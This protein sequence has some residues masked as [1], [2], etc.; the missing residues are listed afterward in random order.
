MV[1]TVAEVQIRV[2]PKLAPT[3]EVLE[4]RIFSNDAL[5]DVWNE[6]GSDDEVAVGTSKNNVARETELT[7]WR[8]RLRIELGG[9]QSDDR[10]TVRVIWSG[11]DDLPLG[12]SVVELLAERYA[13]DLSAD[14]WYGSID[15]LRTKI[16]GVEIA[17]KQLLNSG[18]SPDRI[19]PGVTES[20][21]H[22]FPDGNR[23]REL[24]ARRAAL[25]STMQPDHPELQAAEAALEAAERAFSTPAVVVLTSAASEA[26]AGPDAPRL[27]AP[28]TAN[29][30]PQGESP[31]PIVVTAGQIN[32]AGKRLEAALV[33]L[34]TQMDDI[35]LPREAEFPVVTLDRVGMHVGHLRSFWY[36]GVGIFGLVF[37]TAVSMTRSTSERPS[38]HLVAVEEVPVADVVGDTSSRRP[39]SE[40]GVRVD[41]PSEEASPEELVAAELEAAESPSDPFFRSEVE[42]EQRL[43]APVL[44]VVTRRRDVNVGN[45]IRERRRAA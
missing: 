35:L 16:K 45:V 1:E 38:P 37:A 44:A 40:V 26:E 17:T 41:P 33:D 10:R 29:S 42:V 15:R 43:A 2:V 20:A 36:F 34:Q 28:N 24:L 13:D 31:K 32:V 11:L 39:T 14:R 19:G 8:S 22:R 27:I 4:R 23:Y 5:V 6:V 9:E 18:R 3:P 21:P 25:A 30:L 12:T 7:R